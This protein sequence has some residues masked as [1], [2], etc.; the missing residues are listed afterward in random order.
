MLSRQRW[1]LSSVTVRKLYLHQ[2][3]QTVNITIILVSLITPWGLFDTNVCDKVF[4]DSQQ[5]LFPLGYFSLIYRW[6]LVPLDIIAENGTKAIQN[7]MYGFI[8][9]EEC[10][11]MVKII[12]VNCILSFFTPVNIKPRTGIYSCKFEILNRNLPK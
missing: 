5:E 11:K 6:N 3:M 4:S 9:M 1:R 8:F 12:D 10:L 7:A 2:C